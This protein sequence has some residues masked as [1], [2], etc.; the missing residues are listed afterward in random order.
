MSHLDFDAVGITSEDVIDAGDE[1]VV[2]TRDSGRRKGSGAEVSLWGAD[3]WTVRPG[4]VA[5]AEFYADRT[6]AFETVGLSE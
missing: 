5:P 3:D 1:A 4:K 2:L 6:D